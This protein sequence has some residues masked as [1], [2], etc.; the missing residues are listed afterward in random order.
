MAKK[1]PRR[2]AFMGADA[3]SD[4]RGY[5]A[6]IFGAPHG[7]PYRGIDNRV[8]AGTAQALRAALMNDA[9]WL[10]H[11]D[12]DLGGPMLTERFKLADLGDLKTKPSDGLGNRQLIRS[13]TAE[14][15]SAGAVPVMI[16]GDDS[17]RIICNI[18]GCL[19]RS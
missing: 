15:L 1:T 5:N 6:A 3:A 13:Q 4:P 7:T 9:E 16:G 8:H 2:L 17:T 11:W 10:H 19:A 12:F 14:I 18:L